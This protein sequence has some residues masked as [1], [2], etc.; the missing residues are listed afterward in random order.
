PFWADLPYTDI[1]KVICNDTLHGLHKAF[2]D[3][4]AQWNINCVTP[5][6]IDNQVR[7]LPKTP[8]FR[9]F[10]GGISKISQWSGQEAKD[11]EHI[12]LPLLA[13]VQTPSAIRATRAELDLIHHAGWKTLGED[14]LKRMKDFNK[15]FHDN[16][17]AFL[18]TPGR[19]GREQD[20]FNIPKPHARHHYPENIRWLGAPYNYPTEISEHYQIEVAKKA[21]KAT[22]RKEYVKQMLLWLSRQEKIYLRGMLLRW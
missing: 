7:C 22:N 6:E 4:T 5:F 17:N 21:Y 11:L 16:K 13:G 1:C 19:G 3:H 10:S 20:H 14:D 2:K 12:F 9:H 18:Q 15:I 8:G